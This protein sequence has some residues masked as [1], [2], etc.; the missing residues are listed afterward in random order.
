MRGPNRK[1]LVVVTWAML[2]TT[3]NGLLSNSHSSTIESRCLSG[4]FTK[5]GIMVYP[6]TVVAEDMSRIFLECLMPRQQSTADC[7]G[8]CPSLKMGFGS[9]KTKIIK[10]RPLNCLL[11]LKW[12]VLSVL[13]LVIC[14]G[15]LSLNRLLLDHQ[16]P[17][18][19]PNRLRPSD[20]SPGRIISFHC[21]YLGNSLHKYKHK[22]QVPWA[23]RLVFLPG[24]LPGFDHT[25][26]HRSR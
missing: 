22:C 6:L 26:R 15:F 11:D 23:V 2:G 7:R 3:Y 16:G 14:E 18:G 12:S 17:R 5:F 20:D 1:E 10:W 25:S 21:P 19:A 4:S 24:R 9:L 8:I 13:W